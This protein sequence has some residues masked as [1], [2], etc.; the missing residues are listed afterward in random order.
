M[1]AGELTDAHG[2]SP[3]YNSPPDETAK[4]QNDLFVV[5]VF[6]VDAF[7]ARLIALLFK[8]VSHG[9]GCL[10]RRDI[11]KL[12]IE[13]FFALPVS[14]DDVKCHCSSF[15]RRVRRFVVWVFSSLRRRGRESYPFF[16]PLEVA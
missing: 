14:S 9:L 13:F 15:P 16:Q 5:F 8:S 7:E 10:F 11:P 12:V 6:H 4:I 1:S 3:V 2:W